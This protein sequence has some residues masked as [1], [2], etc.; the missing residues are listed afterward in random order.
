MK[1][2]NAHANLTA[3]TVSEAVPRGKRG[4]R[5]GLPVRQNAGG[6]IVSEMW[7]GAAGARRTWR[8]TMI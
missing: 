2:A 8:G 4:L 5:A 3:Q 1:N 6:I 7:I